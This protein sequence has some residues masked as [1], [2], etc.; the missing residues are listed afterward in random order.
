ME[1]VLKGVKIN[2]ISYGQ[3]KDILL[4]HG[5]GQNI[6]MMKQVGDG[7]KDNYRI[8]ILDLPGFGKSEEPKEPWTL[9]DY[10]EMIEYASL[11]GFIKWCYWA[12]NYYTR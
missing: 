4:L 7:L 1:I 5:W 10:N 3:G 6:E 9:E 11:V 8:T 2:Y 12:I